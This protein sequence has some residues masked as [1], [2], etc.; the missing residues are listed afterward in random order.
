MVEEQT[1]NKLRYFVAKFALKYYFEHSVEGGCYPLPRRHWPGNYWACT[2]NNPIRVG[3]VVLLFC[4]GDYPGYPNEIPGIG[5]VYRID[6]GDDQ[7]TLWYHHISLAPSIDGVTTRTRLT[8]AGLLE[9][10]HNI[11]E[12]GRSPY[13]L[14]RMIKNETARALLEGCQINW[15]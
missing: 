6:E 1:A 15:P 5:I 13:C 4:F 10:L 3:D 7:N 12:A 8:Q 2:P 14:L 11:L 9:D